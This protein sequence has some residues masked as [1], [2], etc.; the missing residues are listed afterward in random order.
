[1]PC[2]YKDYINAVEYYL[3]SAIIFCPKV[4]ILEMFK[5]AENLQ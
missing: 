2:K 1:M 3:F 5:S 4:F